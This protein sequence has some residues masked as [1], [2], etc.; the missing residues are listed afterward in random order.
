MEIIFWKQIV[1][2]TLVDHS[3]VKGFWL[4][5]QLNTLNNEIA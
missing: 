2:T 5:G 3:F 4:R 1:G